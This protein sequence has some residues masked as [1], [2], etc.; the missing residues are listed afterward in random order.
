VTKTGFTV[1]LMTEKRLRVTSMT[2]IELDPMTGIRFKV[3]LMTR[4]G[5]E[6]PAMTGMG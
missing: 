6:V 3:L 2:E 5:L 1:P 4:I